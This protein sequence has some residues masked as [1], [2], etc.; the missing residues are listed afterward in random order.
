MKRNAFAITFLF[1]AF[2]LTGTPVIVL[3]SCSNAEQPEPT[4]NPEPDP[5]APSKD[6][7]PSYALFKLG[8]TLDM[9]LRGSLHLP[10][11]GLSKGD[12]VTI[13]SRLDGSSRDLPC[14][15]ATDTTG[16]FFS[17]PPDLSLLVRWK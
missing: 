14:T 2:L 17:T 16:A 3:S 5:P 12:K 4:P 7:L 10:Y 15:A 8:A 1:A 9:D 13:I 6:L 11:S